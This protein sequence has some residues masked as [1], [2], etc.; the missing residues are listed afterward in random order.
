MSAW[1]WP[2]DKVTVVSI[3]DGDTFHLA[4]DLGFNVTYDYRFR[5]ARCNAPELPT[6]AGIAA[7]VALSKLMPVGT[8]VALVS[9]KP[10]D[11]G[12]WIADLTLADGT[13][14]S[15]W[16]LANGHAVPWQAKP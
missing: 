9:S 10:D 2:A 6:S 7:Q 3:H 16:M 15:D 4:V 12:R 14:V 11:Y 8:H 5:L 13:N 1:S